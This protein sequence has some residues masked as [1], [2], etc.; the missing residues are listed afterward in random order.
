VL[1]EAVAKLVMRTA[2]VVIAIAGLGY[3]LFITA[4]MARLGR[5]A[6]AMTIARLA[7]QRSVPFAFG[8][9]KLGHQLHQAAL[10]GSAG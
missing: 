1:V 5:T 7:K 4:W 3:I 2:V 9:A 10:P 6:T 8:P